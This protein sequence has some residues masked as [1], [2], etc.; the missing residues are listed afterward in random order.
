[1]LNKKRCF[2]KEKSRKIIKFYRKNYPHGKKSEKRKYSVRMCKEIC[3][4]CNKEMR[5]W[6]PR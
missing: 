6:K 3:E 1:M 2:H 5:R 4:N